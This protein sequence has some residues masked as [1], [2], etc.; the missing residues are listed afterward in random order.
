MAQL[1][2]DWEVEAMRSTLGGSQRMTA[3][4]YGRGRQHGSF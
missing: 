3:R 1:K 2:A 4:V